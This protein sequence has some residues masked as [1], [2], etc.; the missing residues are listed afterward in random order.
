[1]INEVCSY[2][3]MEQL[4]LNINEKFKEI[5]I[6]YVTDFCKVYQKAGDHFKI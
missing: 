5:T 3:F 6:K 2:C 1:M 4:T